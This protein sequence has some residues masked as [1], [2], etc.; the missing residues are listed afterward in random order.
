VPE[1]LELAAK[2]LVGSLQGEGPD[3]QS[4]KGLAGEQTNFIVKD[5]PSDVE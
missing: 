4:S 5:L 3:R 1:D 2:K